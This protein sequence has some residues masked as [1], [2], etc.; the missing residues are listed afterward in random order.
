[1]DFQR[2]IR[3]AISD[4][5]NTLMELWDHFL[6]EK[7][8]T[9]FNQNLN[10]GEMVSMEKLPYQLRN[11]YPEA[12]VIIFNSVGYKTLCIQ[13]LEKNMEWAY[14]VLPNV[15]LENKDYSFRIYRRIPWGMHTTN[16]LEYIKCINDKMPLWKAE[17]EELCSTH[18]SAIEQREK[19]QMKRWA[20]ESLSDFSRWYLQEKTDNFL[21]MERSTPDYADR[22]MRTIQ[23]AGL[24]FIKI[25]GGISL[26]INNMRVEIINRKCFRIMRWRDAIK[27]SKLI[28]GIRTYRWKSCRNW[29]GCSRY[30]SRR[31]KP[32]CMKFKRRK[33][34]TK[35]NAT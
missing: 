27:I 8:E 12:E 4:A 20:K 5:R 32:S 15:V 21:M 10:K 26:K 22:I 24:R 29:I 2:F 34:W 1:M 14:V 18:Q 11:L 35:S 30:G 23:E 9:T 19:K 33:S 6:M 16:T 17:F 28:S 3:N 13:E 31:Q 7:V 25:Q